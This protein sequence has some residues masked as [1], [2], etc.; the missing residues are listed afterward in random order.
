M[1]YFDLHCDTATEIYDKG[2]G[3]FD[4]KLH[5][6]LKDAGHFRPWVQ[7]FAVWMPDRY[8]GDAA[9]DRF[10][11]V[12]GAF[13]RE[14]QKNSDKIKLCG[15]REELDGALSTG[16]NAAILSIEGSAALGGDLEHLKSAYDMGVRIITLT[17]N[18]ECEAGGGAQSGTGMTPF[19]FALLKKM[20]QLGIVPDVSHLSDAGF[21][22]VAQNDSGVLMASHSNSREIC[23]HRRNLTDSQFQEIIR[24][25]G[26]VGLNLYPNF[27]GGTALSLILKHIDRFLSLGG[28]KSIALGSDFDGCSVLPGGIHSIA[29]MAK[30]YALLV[31]N[32]GEKVADDIFFDNAYHFI[33]TV[34]TDR[35]SCNNINM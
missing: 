27:L 11:N 30:L 13:D 31:K 33:Q 21:D 6:S 8:R 34:L 10:L 19:G 20:R 24:R 23:G 32:Y 16:K 3:L 14:I 17:W 28:G 5:I 25:G 29:D 26:I 35:R 2:C 12:C 4:N 1:R 15:N 22:D 9:W 18:G 7:V